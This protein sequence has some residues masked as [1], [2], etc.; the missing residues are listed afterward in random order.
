M[1]SAILITAIIL[2]CLVSGR[3]MSSPSS[4]FAPDC[5]P[6]AQVTSVSGQYGCFLFTG[7]HI[8]FTAPASMYHWKFGDGATAT[9]TSVLHCYSPVT[10][11]TVFTGTLSY[12]TPAL[13][14]VIPLETTFT[15]QVPAKDA[16]KCLRPCNGLLQAGKSVTVQPPVTYPEVTIWVDFGDGTQPSQ[17]RMDHTYQNCG[18]Y[19]TKT[20]VRDWFTGDTCLYRCAVNLDCTNQPTGI[21]YAESRAVTAG[22]NPFNE[23]IRLAA[24]G[25]ISQVMIFDA[26]GKQVIRIN[27]AG[28][29]NELDI[30]TEHLPQGIYFIRAGQKEGPQLTVKLIKL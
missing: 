22:P 5:T 8:T 20:F 14:G 18:S 4:T 21:R 3:E 2:P 19:I 30:E 7:S 27:D 25:S 1:K 9:G 6:V 26:S 23:R 10:V 16:Q 13:C 15:V 28:E 29:K 11:T 17:S 24:P 12:L